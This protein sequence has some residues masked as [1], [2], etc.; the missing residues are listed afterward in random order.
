LSDQYNMIIV[1]PEGETVFYLDSPVNQGSQFETY[2]TKK[3]LVKL[4]I[5]RLMI[6]RS[7]DYGAFYG[8]SWSLV[9]FG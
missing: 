7:R 8:R 2:I 9:S 4:T 6:E 5:E 1:M 3:S